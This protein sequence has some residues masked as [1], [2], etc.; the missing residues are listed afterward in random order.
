MKK[1][2][3]KSEKKSEKKTMKNMKNCSS[4]KGGKKK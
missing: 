4:K 1:K 3:I 2:P